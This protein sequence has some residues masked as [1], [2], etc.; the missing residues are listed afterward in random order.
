MKTATWCVLVAL[1]IVGI[2]SAIERAA[3]T[4]LSSPDAK[5]LSPATQ[6]MADGLARRLDLQRGSPDFMLLE[7][8]LLEATA[9]Y[10]A[11]PGATLLHV[12]PGIVVL[13]LGLTQFSGAI[14]SRHPR[15]HRVSGRIVLIAALAGVLSG[16]FFGVTMPYGG[17]Y[18]TTATVAFG[19]FMIYA[20]ARAYAAI[21]RR[22]IAT[23]REWMIRMFAVAIAIAVMRVLG[24]IWVSIAPAPEVATARAFGLNLWVGWILTLAVAELRIRAT[25]RPLRGPPPREREA[26]TGRP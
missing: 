11:S 15:F 24:A 12:L 26:Y 13:A 17:M 2:A 7:G 8:N 3:D 14:R 4:V 23:H 25:R 6:A 21:R 20:G 18:E 5:T 10:R 19:A 9:K 22:D 16:L 1:A